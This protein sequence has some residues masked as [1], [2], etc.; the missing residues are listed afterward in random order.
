MK[1]SLDVFRREIEGL[2]AVLDDC[3]VVA[4]LQMACSSIRQQLRIERHRP[5]T[6]LERLAVLV[7]RL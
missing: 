3:L 1:Q 6:E 2:A 5:F 7:V 4:E